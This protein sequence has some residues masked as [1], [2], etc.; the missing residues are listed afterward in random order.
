MQITTV[1]FQQVMIFEISVSDP[2]HFDTDPDPFQFDTDPL[3]RVAKNV[4]AG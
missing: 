4:G 3:V 2:I 1:F